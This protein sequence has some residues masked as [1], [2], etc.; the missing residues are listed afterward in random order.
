MT[1]GVTI[2]AHY[3]NLPQG[4]VHLQIWDFG[5]QLAYRT[6]VARSL[7]GVSGIMLL[8][9]LT[10]Y[11]TFAELD[12]WRV[13]IGNVRGIIPILLVGCK[14]DLCEEDSTAKAISDEEVQ[15]YV[16]KHKFTSYIRTSAKT[17]KNIDLSFQLMAGYLIAGP[18][19][20]LIH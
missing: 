18:E 9:D 16:Q 17:G 14:D 11:S 12:E 10:R 6:L 8:F 5:G 13:T 7:E 20:R 15:K 3:V 19:H 4:H 2:A 1:M